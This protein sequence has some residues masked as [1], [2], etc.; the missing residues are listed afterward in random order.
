MEQP[1]CA[2][3]A[4]TPSFVQV[5]T[6]TCASSR[7]IT[8]TRS[9]QRSCSTGRTR[10]NRS[11]VERPQPSL[12][13]PASTY[14][15]TVA[16][17]WWCCCCC[18]CGCCDAQNAWS[19]NTSLLIAIFMIAVSMIT[20]PSYQVGLSA[21]AHTVA[22]YVWFTCIVICTK[23][24]GHNKP[25]SHS[26]TCLGAKELSPGA[27]LLRTSRHIAFS[28][29]PKSL[30]VARANSLHSIMSGYYG[31]GSGSGGYGGGGIPNGWP[32]F[33]GHSGWLKSHSLCYICGRPFPSVCPG[34]TACPFKNRK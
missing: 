34:S 28:Q 12:Q 7:T 23:C 32:G 8:T 16:V 9:T 17:M 6:S 29:P 25:I 21:L 22:Q 33:P 5:I 26:R 24:Q 1:I 3:T 11:L 20:L 4:K 19:H 13:V 14:T 15:T 10:R 18:G 31:S 30:R 2:V 27:P